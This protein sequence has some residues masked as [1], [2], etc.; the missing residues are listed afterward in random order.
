[1]NGTHNRV[2]SHQYLGET[3]FNRRFDSSAS[4]KLKNRSMRMGNTIL[5]TTFRRTREY[6]D[7]PFR[8]TEI[9]T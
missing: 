9:E 5:N 2:W 1:M 3:A 4:N 8:T 7:L 6:N